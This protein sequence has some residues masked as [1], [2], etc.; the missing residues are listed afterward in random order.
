[1]ENNKAKSDDN[2]VSIEFIQD[3]ITAS[4]DVI[5]LSYENFRKNFYTQMS[6]D[7]TNYAAKHESLGKSVQRELQKN[8]KSVETSCKKNA[9]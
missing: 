2:S 3:F 9:E 1:M 8:T 6:T 4:T 7:S 5:N